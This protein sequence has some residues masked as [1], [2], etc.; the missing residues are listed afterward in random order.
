[1][2]IGDGKTTLITNLQKAK[3]GSPGS[4]IFNVLGQPVGKRSESGVLPN[5]PKGIYL[6]VVK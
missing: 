2:T 6:E 1:V 3:M 5:L 4:R